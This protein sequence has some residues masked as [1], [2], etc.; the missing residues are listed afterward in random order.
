MKKN[1][2][3]DITVRLNNFKIKTYL[4]RK[5]KIIVKDLQRNK[6]YNFN[7]WKIKNL[8]IARKLLSK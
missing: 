8:N 7:L 6:K 4:G 5:P 2:N 1:K 3:P